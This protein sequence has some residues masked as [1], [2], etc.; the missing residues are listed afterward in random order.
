MAFIILRFKTLVIST[1]I[2]QDYF[3]V[4]DTETSGLPKKWDAPYGTKNNWSHVLQI[5]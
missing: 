5:A 1:T 2:L 4:I 3:L